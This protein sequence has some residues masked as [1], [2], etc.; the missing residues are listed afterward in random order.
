MR[1]YI[2]SVEQEYVT[3]IADY[4]THMAPSYWE[5]QNGMVNIS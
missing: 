5:L 2:Q 3:S 1:R 4:K